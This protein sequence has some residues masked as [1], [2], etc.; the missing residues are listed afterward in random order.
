MESS[1]KI[2]KQKNKRVEKVRKPANPA[3]IGLIVSVILV[4]ATGTG[5]LI[6]QLSKNI[7]SQST[8]K[9][10]T[11]DGNS[12]SFSTADESSIEN[13]AEKLSASVVSII[14]T[15]ESRSSF[16]YGYGSQS[17]TAGTGVIATSDGYIITN[18][19]VVAD[20]TDIQ[21]I[22]ADGTTY[23]NVKVIATDP[24][25]D[26]AYLKIKGVSDLPA[27]E[28]GDSKTLNIG[29]EVIAIGNALGQ[30]EGTVTS[31]I[32]SGVNR[33]VTASSGGSSVA[34]ETLSDMIQTD[35]AINSGNSG[36]PLVNAKGQVIGI[37][38]AVASDAQGI[39]FAIPISA[40]KGMLKS[41]IEDGAADRASL[42]VN[43]TQITATVAKENNLPVKTGAWIYSKS[44]LSVIKSG[45]AAEKAGVK[46]GDIITAVNGVRIGSAGSVSSLIGE[47]RAGDS[48]K[49]TVVR[50][51]K[52][53]ELTAVLDAYSS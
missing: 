5:I 6:S 28:L 46:K 12:A 41:L 38:T 16:F 40:T 52:E 1:E 39:G 48:V 19:H 22:L 14:G 11:E 32:I 47:Y 29:Q 35:A 50:D 25:N 53:I 44:G 26:I 18:K 3:M 42:G 15:A 7:S 33:T 27:A 2:I 9:N 34:V 24:L 13:I 31:G 8:I 20:T 30:Y 49:L 43:Y 21:V 10:A 17:T 36:G 23:E 4:G 51:G 37:N 45:S